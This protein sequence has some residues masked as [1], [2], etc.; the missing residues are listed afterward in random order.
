MYKIYYI[1]IFI[2]CFYL[3]I[4]YMSLLDTILIKKYQT[5]LGLSNFQDTGGNINLTG[6]ITIVNSLFISSIS[7]LQGSTTINSSIFV[8]GPSTINNNNILGTLNVSNTSTLNNVSMMSNLFTNN[9]INNNNLQVNGNTLLLNNSTFLSTIN[10]SGNTKIENKLFINNIQSNNNINIIGNIINIGTTNSIVNIYGTTNFIATTDLNISDKLISLNL[11]S[12]NAGPA[13]IGNLSGIEILGISGTGY[14]KTTSD[15]TRFQIKPPTDPNSYYIG[16]LDMNNNLSISGSTTIMNN[17][18]I[19]SSLN[20][21]NN[22]TINGATTIMS[23]LNISNNTVLLGMVSINSNLYISNT[24]VFNTITILSSLNISGSSNINN[25]TILSSLNVSSY[26]VLGNSVTLN[27]TLSLPS[28]N[29]FIGNTTISSYLNISGNT[30]FIGNVTFNSTLNISNKSI[31]DCNTTI[32]STLYVSNIT[33]LNGQ[34][35]I[36]SNLNISNYTIINNNITIGSILNINGSIISPLP[37][38]LTNNQAVL[39]GIPNFGFY[40]TGG[41]IKIRLDQIAPV[42]TLSGASTFTLTSENYID[43]GAY[44]IDNIDGYCPIYLDSI[45]DSNNNIVINGPILISGTSTLILG[46]NT[47]IN[48]Y[49]TTNYIA[50]DSIGNIGYNY[51]TININKINITTMPGLILCVLPSTYNSSSNLWIDV[52]NNATVIPTSN[53]IW[54]SNGYFVVQN[55]NSPSQLSVT[56]SGLIN[57]MRSVFLILSFPNSISNSRS[58]INADLLQSNYISLGTGKNYYSD[59]PFTAGYTDTIPNN[60]IHDNKFHVYIATGMNWGNKT[61][62]YFGAYNIPTSHSIPAGTRIA[63]I[64]LFDHILDTTEINTIQSWFINSNFSSL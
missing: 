46:T 59:L 4:I 9:I 8:S 5:M 16:K 19:L 12:S 52:I 50:S 62:L 58:L 18:T 41:I 36:N 25:N 26:V 29:L 49:Y 63:A 13:D 30:N 23:S 33:I 27:S 24:S 28:N 6:G 44:S 53:T 60:G 35:S 55:S 3:Y 61:K 7:V 10:I 47:L 38:Y 31:I 64:G 1:I 20:V 17:C 15:G 39:A 43:P 45:I 21:I 40:R 2:K 56:S 34:V 22:T 11:N 14:I 37:E 51:R 57:S 48:G 42:I 54:N 32:G